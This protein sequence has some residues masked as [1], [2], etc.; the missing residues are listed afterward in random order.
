MSPK[1][2]TTRDLSTVKNF[3]YN[4]GESSRHCLWLLNYEPA[5][6]PPKLHQNH[7][8]G[9]A[10]H[11]VGLH[12]PLATN[13]KRPDDFVSVRN[14]QFQAQGRP[15]FY[16]CANVWYGCYLSEA[17][18][19]GGR[20]R[21]VRE[22]DQLQ[23]LG[24]NNLRL[25]AGS[26]TSP[27]VGAIPNGVTRSPHDYD[28]ALLGGLDFCLPEMATRNMRGIL[29][30]SNYWQSSGSFAQY[31]SWIN[32]EKIP[33][34]DLPKIAAGDWHAFMQFSASFCKTP[35][36]VGLYREFVDRLIRRRNTI[37]DRIYRDDPAIMTWE[38]ANKPRLGADDSTVIKDVPIFCDWVDATAIFIHAQDPNHLV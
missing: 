32:G 24:V 34:P 23:K 38:L 29:F 12:P 1:R 30:L 8:A 14:G 36:A 6:L 35:A 31:V 4:L 9:V 17:A 15:Y 16:V 37:N 18:L 27:L 25:L 11:R 20:A 21:F 19:P 26:E 28:K 7:R 5:R 33:D 2:G 10:L 13:S 3:I 22:L